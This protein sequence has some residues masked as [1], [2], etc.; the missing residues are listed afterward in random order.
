MIEVA[1]KIC[2]RTVSILIDSGAS[3]NYVALSVVLNCSLKKSDL[4]VARLVQVTSRTKRKVTKIVRQCPLEMNG[5]NT[6]A[7]LNFI[8]LGSYDVLIGIDWLTTK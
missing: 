7:Y 8:P 6:L 1:G 5:V 4:E 2:N 3:N